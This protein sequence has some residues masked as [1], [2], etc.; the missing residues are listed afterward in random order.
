MRYWDLEPHEIP[1]LFQDL[2]AR[3]LTTVGAWVPWADLETDQK[4]RLRRFLVQAIRFQFKVRLSVTPEV[5]IG[6]PNGGVPNDLLRKAE[7]IAQDRSGQPIYSFAPPNMHPLVN[8]VAPQ[9]FQRFGHFLLKL[10]Q[11]IKEV[12]AEHFDA[13]IDLI[14][15]DSFFKH[16]RTLGLGAEDHGDYASLYFQKE[17]D[18]IRDWNPAQSERTFR[19]RA[20]DFLQSRFERHQSVRVE[21]RNFSVRS[22]SLDRLLDEI[23]GSVQSAPEY[24]SRFYESRH[25][26]NA[27]W[28]DDL[29]SINELGLKFVLSSGMMLYGDF[30]LP[31]EDL[32]R[33]SPKFLSRLGQIG[34][35]LSMS[36]NYFE[37]SVLCM[38]KNP[39][40]VARISQ[41]LREKLGPRMAIAT[42]LFDVPDIKLERT[43]LLFVEEALVIEN[44]QFRALVERAKQYNYTLALF[45]SSLCKRSQAELSC[46]ETFKI[47]HGWEYEVALF[48]DGGQLLVID[49]HEST[50][51][52]M[53]ELVTRILAVAK[54]EPVLRTNSKKV[55]ANFICNH[56]DESI[57]TGFLFNPSDVV[58]ELQFTIPRS[59]S[60]EGIEARAEEENE[61]DRLRAEKRLIV[62]VPPYAVVPVLLQ[63]ESRVDVPVTTDELLE[64]E[65]LSREPERQAELV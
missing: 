25:Y 52:N 15:G 62:Q 40:S 65:L 51:S 7:N 47:K 42:S 9:V 32:L 19:V 3:G 38:V 41:I 20:V 29:G 4:S 14:V 49:G 54:A 11:E 6:Y 13:E 48:P 63:F 1:A 57:V 50:L 31:A 45:R 10:S 56:M 26:C 61:S 33:L 36:E 64:E 30:W 16:Y 59:V 46:F 58:E 5:A 8:L 43:K 23:V 39:F 27:I 22:G 55:L 35:S 34:Q 18:A 12:L 37:Q 53:E 28:C 17:L 21:S 2:K 60:I 44:D 24:F